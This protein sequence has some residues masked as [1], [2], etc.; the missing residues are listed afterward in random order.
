VNLGYANNRIM[1]WSPDGTRLATASSTDIKIWRS[2]APSRFGERVIA[3]PSG[4]TPARIASMS[5]D[6]KQ[7]AVSS[8]GG[9]IL[10]WD[11][12]KNKVVRTLSAPPPRI[13]ALAWSPD[14]KRLG[15]VSNEHVVRVWDTER[16][17]L[18][19]TLN[20][21][22][23]PTSI[24]W[25]RDGQ[26]IASVAGQGSLSIWDGKTGALRL[27]F[28]TGSLSD[29][30]SWSPDGKRIVSATAASLEIWEIASRK[31]VTNFPESYASAVAWSPSG[32]LVA[33]GETGG[34]VVRD[35]ASG[36]VLHQFGEDL[37]PVRSISWSADGRRIF[38][39]TENGPARMWDLD[40]KSMVRAACGQIDGAL[41][42]REWV[43]FFGP[44]VP[45]RRSCADLPDPEE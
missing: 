38:S 33:S 34:V 4:L 3:L 10:I 11:L 20:H 9:V 41:T 13:T 21:A 28:P 39:L 27:T 29:G 35:V 2:P 32:K 22:D 40:S 44:N 14:G 31:K 24:C 42:S 25:S 45:Y 18:L 36:E 23:V 17:A 8:R 5:P 15:S 1:T 16:G 37:G 43:K 6:E 19:F 7:M 30:I 26:S 12:V